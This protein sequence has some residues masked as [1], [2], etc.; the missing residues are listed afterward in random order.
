METSRDDFGIAIRS[1]F[2]REATRG[3]FSLLA[4]IIFSIILL[5]L[6]S[7]KLKPIDY[8]KSF[9]RDT[10]YRSS[11]IV[12]SPLT[13]FKYISNE[14]GNHVNVYK[15]YAQLK[16]EHALLKDKILESDFLILENTQLRN[17]LD[18]QVNSPSNLVSSR[19]IIDKQSPYLNSFIINSGSNRKIINVKILSEE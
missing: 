7:I 4:L 18:E 2:L 19:V 8:F 15:N 14:I 11:I 1:A 17:L 12:S 13:G 5:F 9:L 3:R 6:E 10:I 16:K